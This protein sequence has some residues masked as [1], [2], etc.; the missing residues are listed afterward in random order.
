MADEGVERDS[1]A[2]RK[3]QWR[4]EQR[5][6]EEAV[7]LHKWVANVDMYIKYIHKCVYYKRMR[8]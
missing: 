8:Y 1:R 4:Q 7:R 5:D 6:K 3:Q 2:L